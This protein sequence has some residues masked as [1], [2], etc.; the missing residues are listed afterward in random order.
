MLDNMTSD[1][2]RISHRSLFFGR[3]V[4][5]MAAAFVVVFAAFFVFSSL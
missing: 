5:I 2:P 1:N 3:C 4:A